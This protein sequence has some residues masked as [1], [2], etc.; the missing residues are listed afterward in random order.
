MPMSS[1][2]HGAS[3]SACATRPKAREIGSTG[4]AGPTQHSSFIGHYAMATAEHREPY[5]SR[6]SR[7]VLG[8]PG[9]ETPPGDS[10][11]ATVSRHP[12]QVRASSGFGR[13][14]PQASSYLSLPQGPHVQQGAE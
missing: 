13:L 6:G 9:G 3:S 12:R 5:E 7:T 14:E 8:A 2:G 1:G 10:S 11:I 4:Y